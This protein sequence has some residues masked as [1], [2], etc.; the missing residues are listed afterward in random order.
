MGEGLVILRMLPHILI[1]MLCVGAWVFWVLH[2]S[3]ADSCVLLA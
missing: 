2:D 3:K 1:V